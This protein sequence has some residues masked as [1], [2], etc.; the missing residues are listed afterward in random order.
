[1]S[2]ASPGSGSKARPIF[3]NIRGKQG[4]ITSALPGSAANHFS[5]SDWFIVWYVQIS[6]LAPLGFLRLRK[7]PLVDQQPSVGSGKG[8]EVVYATL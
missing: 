5:G 8:W 4:R 7:C 2:I 3:G 1:M 6:L